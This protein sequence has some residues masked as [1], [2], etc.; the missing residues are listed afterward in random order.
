LNNLEFEL[1]KTPADPGFRTHRET[2]DT[3]LCPLNAASWDSRDTFSRL[4]RRV[5]RLLQLP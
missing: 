3:W 5:S 2:P 1:Q 4:S